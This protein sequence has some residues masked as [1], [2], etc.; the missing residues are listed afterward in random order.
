MITINTKNIIKL[1]AVFVIFISF[2]TCS[3]DKIKKAI[4][5]SSYHQEFEVQRNMLQTLR[6]NLAVNVQTSTLYLDSKR[7]TQ[8]AVEVKASQLL[9]RIKGAAADVIF[10]A[11]DNAVIHLAEKLLAQSFNV[12]ILGVNENPRYY[13]DEAKFSNLKGVLERPLYLRAILELKPFYPSSTDITILMDDTVTSNLIHSKLFED[14]EALIGRDM[15]IRYKKITD[16]QSLVSFVETKNKDIGHELFV[17]TLFNIIDKETG[18]I[19]AM[20][21]ILTWLNKHYR[22]PIYSFWKTNVKEHDVLAAY[23]SS[24]EAQGMNAAE[25]GNDI[26]L[27]KKHFRDFVTPNEG[28]FYISDKQLEKYRIDI[29]KEIK[30]KRFITFK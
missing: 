22:K 29:P 28:T 10:L 20:N 1:L 8:K 15:T 13:V 6:D 27:G 16:F 21:D 17:I 19:V 9:Q 5:V 12:V 18:K 26:I 4:I 23:G 11:D 25:I 7:T 14:N 3:Q 30:L 24:E 2:S